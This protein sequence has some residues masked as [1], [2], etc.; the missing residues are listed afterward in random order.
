MVWEQLRPHHRRMI[1]AALD[2]LASQPDTGSNPQVHTVQAGGQDVNV[3]RGP[4]GYR[5]FFKQGQG[6]IEVIDIASRAQIDFL[7]PARESA[8]V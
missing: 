5:V 3:L 1:R 2:R 8:S 6:E 7:R 4:D